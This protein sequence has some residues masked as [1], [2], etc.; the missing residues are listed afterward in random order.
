M[1]GILESHTS[2]NLSN[3]LVQLFYFVDEVATFRR[4]TDLQSFQAR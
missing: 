3:Y 4:M 1:E 2:K